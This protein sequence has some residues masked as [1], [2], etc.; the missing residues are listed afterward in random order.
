MTGEARR[1]AE[2][3]SYHAH[4]YFEPGS[5][6]AAARRLR[7]GVANRFAVRL[8]TWHERP[9]GPHDRPMFQIAFAADLFSSLVPW[10]MLNHEDLS[11]LIHPNTARPRRDHMS[12]SLWIGQPLAIHEEVLPE[13]E[14]EPEQ[15]GEPNTTP[16]LAP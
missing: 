10:L 1:I 3:V 9:V 2:I 4:V 8:G 6:A 7:E 13:R 5:Q 16:T 11:I 15:A 14:D 12:D